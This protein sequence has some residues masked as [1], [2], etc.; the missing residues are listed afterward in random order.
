MF[1][2]QDQDTCHSERQRS[3]YLPPSPILSDAA[4]TPLPFPH[5]Q[6]FRESISRLQL[7]RTPGLYPPRAVLCAAREG[8]GLPAQPQKS[9]RQQRYP[10]ERGTCHGGGNIRHPASDRGGLWGG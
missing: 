2:F 10:C 9:Y 4:P 5:L 7:L 1:L 3:L 8:R 6:P